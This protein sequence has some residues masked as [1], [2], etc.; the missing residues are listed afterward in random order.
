MFYGVFHNRASEVDT[1]L[2]AIKADEACYDGWKTSGSFIESAQHIIGTFE[3]RW[4][5]IFRYEL[6]F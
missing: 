4:I 6:K 3:I 2:S 5:Y 1:T